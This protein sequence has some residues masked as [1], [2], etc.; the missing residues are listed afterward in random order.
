MNTPKLRYEME[1]VRVV[2]LLMSVIH[3]VT[4]LG[5][6]WRNTVKGYGILSMLFHWLMLLLL[7]AV[8]ATMEFKSNYP[9]GSAGRESLAVW[10]YTLGLSVFVLVWLRLLI[11]SFGSS[12][13]IDPPPPAWQIKLARYMHWTLYLLLIGLPLLG[14]L[15]LSAK[16]TPIP[17]FGIELPA[18]IDKSE[19]L[20]KG[21]KQIHEAIATA[22]YF[23]IGAHACAALYH[24]YVQRDNTLR[25]MS[26]LR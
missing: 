1:G 15:V 18:L 2:I 22:G 11:Q 24:H 6:R 16:G 10:H 13:A 5:L 20:A 9:R 19:S 7:V 4:E 17:F 8:Y 26:P 12:P 3:Q 25:L 21:L 23:L 14:W